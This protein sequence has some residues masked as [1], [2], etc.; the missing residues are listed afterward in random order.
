VTKPFVDIDPEA[1]DGLIA[2]V[3]DARE[4]G[5]ALS[6]ADN[7]LL[8]DALMTLVQVQERL[9]G[10]DITLHKLRKLLGIVRSSE[11]HQ[12]C[13]GRRQPQRHRGR[14]RGS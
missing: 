14:Q 1:L 10:Q 12:R 11:K 5:L 4:Y 6:A 7:Q 2:R 9:T 13:V 8:L 3:T